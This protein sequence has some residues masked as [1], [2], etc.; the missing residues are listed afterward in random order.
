MEH[1]G[2]RDPAETSGCRVS[3]DMRYE[4]HSSLPLYKEAEESYL[5]WGIFSFEVDDRNLLSSFSQRY[6][7]A[8][9][10]SVLPSQKRTH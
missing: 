6:T 1:Y 8:F 5:S 3:V 2:S 9:H 7:K 10:H 4:P